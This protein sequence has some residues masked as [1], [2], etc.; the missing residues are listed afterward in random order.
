MEARHW[1]LLR[2]QSGIVTHL[3]FHMFEAF[4]INCA[5][6]LVRVAVFLSYSFHEK[7]QGQASTPHGPLRCCHRDCAG[8]RKTAVLFFFPEK[9]LQSGVLGLIIES[10]RVHTLT[11]TLSSPPLIPS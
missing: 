6:L 7:P 3:L 11:G 4:L 10:R 1:S 9:L 8:S 5:H 2:A